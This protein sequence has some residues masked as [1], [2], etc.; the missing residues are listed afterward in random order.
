M[1][2]PRTFTE[3]ATKTGPIITLYPSRA[4]AE[5]AL[6]GAPDSV[7][8]HQTTTIGPWLPAEDGAR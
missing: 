4:A 1:T 8:V 3:W 5:A 2:E 6:T 7:L